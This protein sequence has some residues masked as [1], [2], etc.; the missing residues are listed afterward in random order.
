MLTIANPPRGGG[1]KLRDS[2]SRPSCHHDFDYTIRLPGS[3]PRGR[4]VTLN[5][6]LDELLDAS[7]EWALLPRTSDVALAALQ[8]L[9]RTFTIDA[10]LVTYERKP[11]TE[12]A[13]YIRTPKRWFS[14]WGLQT[15][16]R[17]LRNAVSAS[18]HFTSELRYRQ[19][20][21][22][23]DLPPVWQDINHRNNIQ[24]VGI[25]TVNF[26]RDP[27]GLFVLAR[28]ATGLPDDSQ[29]ISR[30]MAHIALLME[31][32]ITRRFAEELSLRDPLTGLLNRR[33]LI[34]QF[35]QLAAKNEPLTLAVID[36][37]S[38]KQFN[39]QNGHVAGDS[40]LTKAGDMLH[41]KAEI[42][43]G[44]CARIGGDEFLVAAH[45]T[46]KDVHLAAEMVCRWLAEIGVYASVGC[47]VLG[48]DGDDFDGCYRTADLRLYD[49]K[50]QQPDRF[51]P[52][53]L[54]RSATAHLPSPTHQ[55]EIG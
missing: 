12:G 33:G 48:V 9:R 37:D 24:Q 41:E 19:W 27:V 10:G 46:V 44:V 6:P 38:F 42:Y 3:Q 15:P 21:N 17:D 35:S 30:C 18:K 34:A 31:M 55:A 50:A 43:H 32:V 26:Q 16:E 28:T 11:L 23:S 22:A 47:S 49:M 45:Y 54:I 25:W 29:T 36:L 20:F 5:T 53:D 13:D 4:A 51:R 39:D 2:L 7:R 14:S 8:F 1:A 40:L 52:R